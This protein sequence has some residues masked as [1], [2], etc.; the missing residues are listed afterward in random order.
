MIVNQTLIAISIC[1]VH[2]PSPIAEQ[3]DHPS[4]LIV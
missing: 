2:S 1:Q 3:R 4:I